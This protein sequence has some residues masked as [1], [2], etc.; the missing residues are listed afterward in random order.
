MSQTNQLTTPQFHP[1]SLAKP[2]IIGAA[3]AFILMCLFLFGDGDLPVNPAW[4]KYWWIRPFIVMAFAGAI[5][6]A[7]YYFMDQMTYRGLN[8][9]VAIILSLIVYIIGLWMG[10][11]LGLNGTLWD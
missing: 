8:K 1:A 4:P 6:G 7:F 3:I 5:G 11:V 10:T 9:A 2:M